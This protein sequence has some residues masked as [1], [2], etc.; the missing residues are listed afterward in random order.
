[1]VIDFKGLF[2]FNEILKKQIFS[3]ISKSSFEGSLTY[4]LSKEH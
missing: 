3:T 4:L 2:E 1:M